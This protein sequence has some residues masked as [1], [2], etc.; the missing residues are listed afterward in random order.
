MNTFLRYYGKTVFL[1]HGDLLV[2][3]WHSITQP[4][5]KF[6]KPRR[7]VLTQNFL[8]NLNPGS[9]LTSRPLIYQKS[10][11]NNIPYLAR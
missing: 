11:K 4:K 2:S 7:W 5:K 1:H 9:D 10:R 6:Q 8:L 3:L